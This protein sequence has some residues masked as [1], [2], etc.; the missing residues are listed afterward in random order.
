MTEAKRPICI[1]HKNCADGFGAAW[2]V[3][4]KHGDAFEYHASAYGDDPPDFHGRDVYMVDFSFKRPV[5]ERI[6]LAAETVTVLD[7]HKTAQADLEP[8]M[9]TGEIKGIFDTVLCSSCTR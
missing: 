9:K 8:L 7:H 4:K 3:W 1:Y 5:M 2:A 6:L